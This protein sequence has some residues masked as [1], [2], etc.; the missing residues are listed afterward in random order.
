M[1]WIVSEPVSAESMIQAGLPF[2]EVVGVIL[3]IIAIFT[4]AIAVLHI[5]LALRS[6]DSHFESCPFGVVDR[7]IDR[8]RRT[9]EK[10][11]KRLQA[12]H[13]WGWLLNR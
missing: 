4:L 5:V 9:P 2:V 6:S 7:Y 8:F 3:A 10:R 13:L 12:S 11:M 1:N